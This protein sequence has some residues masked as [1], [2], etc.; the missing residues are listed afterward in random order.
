MVKPSFLNYRFIR[1]FSRWHFKINSLLGIKNSYLKRIPSPQGRMY[2]IQ[3]HLSSCIWPTY[4]DSGQSNCISY[5]V[6]SDWAGTHC[7]F[8]LHTSPPSTCS[9]SHWIQ[10]TL[11]LEYIYIYWDKQNF[12]NWYWLIYH[13]YLVIVFSFV[14]KLNIY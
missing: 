10:S 9:F 12:F 11:T 4:S 14:I 6:Y 1:W 13:F 3:V 8:S 7:L 5:S 2:Q